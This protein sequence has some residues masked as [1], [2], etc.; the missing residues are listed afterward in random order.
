M[1]KL[2]YVL[3]FSFVATISITSC[4]E[5][6]IEPQQTDNQGGQVSERDK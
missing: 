6:A 3:V 1:K 2:I 4:T 5:E